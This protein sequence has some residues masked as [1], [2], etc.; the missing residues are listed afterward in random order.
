MLSLLKKNTKNT[1][2]IEIMGRKGE[3]IDNFDLEFK[4]F[5]QKY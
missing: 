1:H 2:N 5:S 3:G 4:I